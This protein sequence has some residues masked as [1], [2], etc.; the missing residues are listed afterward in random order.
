MKVAILGDG[1][2]SLTLAK[3]LANEGIY[4][5]IFLNRKNKKI[6]PT[7]TLSISR[8]NVEFFDKNILK[9]GKLLWNINQIEI[10]SDTIGKEKILNFENKG[11]KLFSILKNHELYKLLLL[12]LKKKQQY[13]QKI[14]KAYLNFD[15]KILT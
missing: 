10:Y 1:L 15:P 11:Q 13:N 9:I 14:Y 5:D 12:K 7:R 2:I 8:S 6:S 3:S 4:V